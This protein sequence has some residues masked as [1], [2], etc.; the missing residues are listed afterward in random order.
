MGEMENTDLF[1]REIAADDGVV[2]TRNRLKAWWLCTFGGFRIMSV[3]KLPA[4]TIYGGIS[5]TKTW[6]LTPRPDPQ[7]GRSNKR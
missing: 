6:W 1:Q 5:Y 3:S 2:K 4:T 7:N